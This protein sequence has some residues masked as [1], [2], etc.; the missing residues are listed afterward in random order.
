M[1][2]VSPT[3]QKDGKYSWKITYKETALFPFWWDSFCPHEEVLST[4]AIKKHS[5][6]YIQKMLDLKELLVQRLT[7]QTK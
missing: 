7:V 6:S 5:D 4:A 1:R 2:Q 3:V